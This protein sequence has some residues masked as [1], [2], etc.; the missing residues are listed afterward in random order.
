MHTAIKLMGETMTGH[1][2]LWTRYGVTLDKTA[3]AQQNLNTLMNKFGGAEDSYLQTTAGKIGK[4]QNALK[5]LEDEIGTAFL[6]A[7]GDAA[8]AVTKFLKSFTPEGKEDAIKNQIRALEDS[9][10]T[11]ESGMDYYKRFGGTTADTA[12]KEKD[13]QEKI[14]KVNK[15]LEEQKKKLK[16]FGPDMFDEPL[17]KVYAHA[18]P[19]SDQPGPDGS[20]PD[21]KKDAVLDTTKMFKDLSEVSKTGNKDL[22]EIG[23]AASIGTIVTSTAEAVMKTYAEVPTPFNIPA[24]AAAAIAGGVQLAAAQGAQFKAAKG[25]YNDTS[26]SMVGQFQPQEVVIPQRFSDLIASGRVSLHGSNDNSTHGGDTINIQGGNKTVEQILLEVKTHLNNK[27]G[28]RMVRTDGTP[29][30]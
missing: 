18:A 5:L 11:L 3:T 4:A 14:D 29:N 21:A 23:K 13:L 10:S 1:T 2:A 24:A 7:M 27:R 28:G 17:K 25:F 6:P 20:T 22:F 16:E 12:K 15:S 8:T 26:E 30:W 9:K 19:G